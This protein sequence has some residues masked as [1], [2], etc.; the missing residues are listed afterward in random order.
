[1][2]DSSLGKVL[3][4]FQVLDLCSVCM[5]IWQKQEF[6][7]ILSLQICTVMLCFHWQMTQEMATAIMR[8]AYCNT[9][10]TTS[11][12]GAGSTGFISIVPLAKLFNPPYCSSY[13][14]FFCWFLFSSCQDITVLWNSLVGVFCW[15]LLV[16]F[17]KLN[18]LLTGQCKGRSV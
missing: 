2:H 7:C 5:Y 11:Q 10:P 15:Q 1:M 16:W 13:L 17:R 3:I 18:L 8:G 12:T 4:Y 9:L 6:C 14:V